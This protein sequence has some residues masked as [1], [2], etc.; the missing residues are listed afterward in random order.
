MRTALRPGD[1]VALVAPAGPVPADRLDAGVAVLQTWD[2]RV[3]CLPGVRARHPELSYLAG[4]D[5]QRAAE[6]Q[7]AWLDPEVAAVFAARG[8]YGC[9]RMLGLV[10]WAALRAAGPTLFAGSSDTTA[11][12]DAIGVHLGLPTLFSPMPATTHFDAVGAEGLRA[13]L[14]TPAAGR[15]LRGP[16]AETLV[17]GRARG[18]LVGGNLSL[19]AAGLGTPE[20][21]PAR[22]GIALLED[23]GEE[24]YRI[25]RMLTHLLRAGW[26]DGVHGIAL[27]S[28]SG[29]ASPDSVRA[30]VLDRLG[31]LEVPM[32]WDLGFGHHPGA[33]TVPLGVPAQ[34]DA[35]AASLVLEG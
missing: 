6:F 12:H 3:R 20:C 2:L 16:D 31:P 15:V 28:W 11:L 17:P 10:D 33:L 18:T 30:L 13:A 24:L 7:E 22:G 19:L 4:T 29:C 9:Q 21:R 34:L 8:G 14:F 32:V 23:V 27:G 35:D 1:T 5:V 26:F 25:D